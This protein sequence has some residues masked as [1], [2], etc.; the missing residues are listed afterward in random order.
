MAKYGNHC[1]LLPCF[2]TNSSGGTK[3]SSKGFLC[4]HHNHVLA[5]DLIILQVLPFSAVPNGCSL[6]FHPPTKAQT[7][8]VISEE[9]ETTIYSDAARRTVVRTYTET[10]ST[11]LFYSQWPCIPNSSSINDGADPPASPLAQPLFYRGKRK[12][13]RSLGAVGLGACSRSAT[14]LLALLNQISAFESVMF[15]CACHFMD[16]WAS[17]SFG[18]LTC[19]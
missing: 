9:Q 3:S 6:Y 8:A 10:V 15:L 18:Y 7:L 1:P 19:R 12:D 16:C 17:W 14:E 2:A 4:L 5:L 11:I 13:Q